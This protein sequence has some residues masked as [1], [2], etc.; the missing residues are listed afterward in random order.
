MESLRSVITMTQVGDWMVAVDLKDAYFHVPIFQ[1]H[2]KFLRFAM[3][4]K[5]SDCPQLQ[6]FSRRFWPQFWQKL[7]YREFPSTRIWTIF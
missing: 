2:R 5:G 6:G 1:S 4:Y 7:V 3:D